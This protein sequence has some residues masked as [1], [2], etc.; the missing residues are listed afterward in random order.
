MVEVAKGGNTQEQ[1]PMVLRVP[2]FN[3]ESLSVCFGQFSLLGF[4]DI[5]VPGLLVAYCHGF[6]L[7]TTRSRLYFFTGTLSSIASISV[8]HLIAVDISEPLSSL[9]LFSHISLLRASLRGRLCIK[10]IERSDRE[11]NVNAR[12]HR[13]NHTTAHLRAFLS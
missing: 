10:L 6:D 3:N 7:L 1:L 2:H 9:S 4:G 11:K 8:W 5:L 12:N 13:R